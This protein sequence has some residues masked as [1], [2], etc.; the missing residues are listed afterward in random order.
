M[1]R[2]WALAMMDS[3][4][5]SPLDLGSKLKAWWAPLEGANHTLNGSGVASWTDEVGGYVVSQATASSQPTYSAAG[6]NGGACAMFDGSND[7]LALTPVPGGIPTGSAPSEIWTSCSQ[8]APAADTTGRFLVSYGDTGFSTQRR[9]IRAVTAGV[10]QCLL[11]EDSVASAPGDFSG[12]HVVRGVFSASAYVEMDG[13]AGAT[14]AQSLNTGAV[15]IVFGRSSTLGGT[16]AWQGAI[17]EVAITDLL[18]A[19]QAALLNAYL[20]RGF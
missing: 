10:N 19:P 8:D 5:F 4:S 3:A 16:P 18:T 7:Y 20:H 17:R 11:A 9:L 6:F 15:R 14:A 1:I 13:V 12:A 2:A